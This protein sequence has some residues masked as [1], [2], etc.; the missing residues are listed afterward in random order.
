MSK[1]HSDSINGS[2]SSSNLIWKLMKDRR[3]SCESSVFCS[4]CMPSPKLLHRGQDF[5]PTSSSLL[6]GKAEKTVSKSGVDRMVEDL[7]AQ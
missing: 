6:I 2:P 5:F 1:P 7:Q 4:M 3:K